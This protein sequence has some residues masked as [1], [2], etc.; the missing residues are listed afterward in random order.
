MSF[1]AYGLMEVG[2]LILLAVPG[3]GLHQ[4]LLSYVDPA[5]YFNSRRLETQ[6]PNLLEMAAKPAPHAQGTVAQLLS[7]RRLAE[8]KEKLGDQKEPVR[9][10]LQGL[11]NG[12]EGF[13]RDYAQRALARMDGKPEPILYTAAKDSVRVQALEWFPESVT[14][15]GALD[16][17]ALPG[18]AS[19]TGKEAETG[20]KVK[21]MLA[22][23]LK[24]A[25]GTPLEEIYK[26]ID[27]VGDIRVDRVAFGYGPETMAA[28]G[29]AFVRVSGYC[30]QKRIVEFLKQTIPDAKVEERKGP[31]GEPITIVSHREPPA[32]AFIGDTE[33]LMAGPTGNE[34]GSVDLIEAALEV[35]AG[36]KP[37]IVKGILAKALE[38][39]P[40]DARALLVGMVP[41]EVQT[42]LPMTPLA[43]SPHRVAFYVRTPKD[44]KGTLL[45]MK[46]TMQS[47]PDA[48]KLTDGL[49][50]V[51]KTA[52]TALDNSPVPIKKETLDVLKTVLK[53]I[54]VKAEGDT[55]LASVTITPDVPA[56]ML[57]LVNEF[58]QRE[59]RP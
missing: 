38:E 41:P 13:A 39:A 19:L 5:D 40:S 22:E 28:K 48:K 54:Q 10:A 4:D 29:Q 50:E 6:V 27:V 1:V 30:N 24:K 51:L 8:M 17:R 3:S 57:D 33:F 14:F 23:I 25:P 59:F 47:E 16:L 52:V 32:F 58:I 43:A 11:A 18:Q 56:A 45:Q 49:Q 46:G 20:D 36:K 7:I 53:G 34:S 31:K 37:S 42:L 12:P 55:V 26:F 9:K 15:V 44:G 21:K 2:M 35:R